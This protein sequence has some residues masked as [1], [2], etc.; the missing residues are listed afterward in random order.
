MGRETGA[1][2]H[3]H[4]SLR[5]PDTPAVHTFIVCNENHDV[6]VAV[7]IVPL[8]FYVIVESS[9]YSRL[10]WRE[11]MA[12]REDLKGSPRGL[13]IWSWGVEGL[14]EPEK[15][16]V[17]CTLPYGY[18]AFIRCLWYAKYSVI[19]AAPAPSLPVASCLHLKQI[20]SAGTIWFTSHSPFIHCPFPDLPICLCAKAFLYCHRSLCP[21]CSH[22]LPCL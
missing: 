2:P 10:L 7:L 1:V 13:R 9:N 4:C 6:C 14:L 18:G 21:C 3:P 16:E 11:P 17:Q 20:H 19:V 22:P 8:D 5:S 12:P 15:G